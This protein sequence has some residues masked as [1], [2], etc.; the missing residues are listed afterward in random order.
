MQLRCLRRTKE[1]HAS[2][3][4]I[5]FSDDDWYLLLMVFGR[6]QCRPRNRLRADAG[7]ACPHL[8]HPPLG[9]LLRLQA[10]LKSTI[11]FVI[12]R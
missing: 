5:S 7:G 11:Y 8:P 3:T 6:N 4:G 10:L 12:W 2:L 9:R 1:E